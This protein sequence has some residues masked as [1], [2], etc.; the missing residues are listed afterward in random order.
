M[1]AE[2]CGGQSH[3]GMVGRVLLAVSKEAAA[4]ISV[5]HSSYFSEGCALRQRAARGR[6]GG[7]GVLGKTVA[8]AHTVPA[9]PPQLGQPAIICFV[10]SADPALGR[11]FGLHAAWCFLMCA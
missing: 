10:E 9:P 11:Q 5:H 7:R 4:E 1:Q 8:P 2:A 6:A 3:G